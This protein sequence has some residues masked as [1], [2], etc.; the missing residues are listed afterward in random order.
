LSKEPDVPLPRI[1]AP[2][3]SFY[4]NEMKYELK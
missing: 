2:K 4:E 3:L 1:F